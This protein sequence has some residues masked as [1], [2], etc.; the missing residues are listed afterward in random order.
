M[1]LKE[2]TLIKKKYFRIYIAALL[3]WIITVI[4]DAFDSFAAGSY[5]DANAVSAIELVTPMQL[6]IFFTGSIICYGA[7]VRYSQTLGEDNKEKAYKIAGMSLLTSIVTGVVLYAVLMLLKNP[8]LNSYNVSKEVYAYADDYY[9]YNM[10]LALVCP[11][12]YSLY[13]LVVYDG[14]EKNTLIS[15]CLMALVTMA[16]PYVLVGTFGIKGIA[17]TTP[18]SYFGAGAVAFIH[19]F[20]KRSSIHFKPCFMFDELIEAVKC[21][22]S[23]T[24]GSLYIGIVDLVFNKMIVEKFSDLYLPAYGVTNLILNLANCLIVTMTAGGVFISCYYGENN[25][26]AIKRVFKHSLKHGTILSI[27]FSAVLILLSSLIPGLYGIEDPAVFEVSRFACI[28]VSLSYVGY[29]L[30]L[31]LMTYYS[32]TDNILYGNIISILYMLLIPLV[33]VYPLG[34]YFGFNAMNIG[35]ALTPFVSLAVIFVIF[36]FSKRYKSAP[37]FLPDNDETEY[38]YDVELNKENIVELRDIAIRDLSTRN[39][40]SSTINEIGVVIEDVLM[41]IYR[42]NNK[43]VIAEVTILINDE[44]LRLIIKDSGEI[45]DLVK[46]SENA[47]SLRSYTIDRLTSDTYQKANSITTSFNRNIYYWKLK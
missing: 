10:L 32:M 25:P 5:L 21:A 18:L 8:I 47:E 35:F 34:V 38:H 43:K 6:I 28:S 22:S 2:N 39:I 46:K 31:N 11:I 19:L 44:H 41:C 20:S 29:M 26:Y 30:C 24:L 42:N 7:A 13:Y 3:G 37:L 16:G 23:V 36:R 15:D 4:G 40:S 27:V 9:T 17:I 1:L 12:Y 14:D 33:F 45:F